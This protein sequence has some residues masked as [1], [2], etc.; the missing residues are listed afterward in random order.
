MDCVFC[1]I[2][3]GKIPARK[4]YENEH[5]LAF[6]DVNPQAPVHFLVIFKQH[7][8]SVAVLE[9][10]QFNLVQKVFEAIDEIVKILNLKDGFRVVNNCGKS[11]GQTVEHV[12]FHVLAGRNFSWPPG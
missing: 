12:H 6:Y 5:V 10:E 3:A 1:N 7:V 4:I 9:G 2:V 11:A 8:S